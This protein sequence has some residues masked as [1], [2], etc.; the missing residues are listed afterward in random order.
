MP[1]ADWLQGA[2]PAFRLAIATS[3]LAPESRQKYQEEAIQQ[4]MEARP[5]WAEYLS[6][7]DRHLTPALSWAALSR[8]PGLSLPEPARRQLQKRSDACRI[9]GT[10]HSLLLADVLKEFNRAG[11]PAMPLKG[12][13]LS[14]ELYGDVGLRQ[15]DDL[16]LQVPKENLHSAMA[17]LESTGWRPGSDFRAMS[18][19]QWESFLRN[20]YEVQFTHSRAGCSLELHWRNHWETPDATSARW[21]RSTPS[22]WQGRSIR[23]MSA[24][25]LALFLC[26]HGAYHIWCC[27]KW[28]SDVARAHA[29]GRVD[30]RAAQEEARASGLEG[31]CP[32]AL[33]LLHGL[34]G[35]EVPILPGI[36]PDRAGARPSPLLV[37]M[38]LESL[39]LSQDPRGRTGLALLRNHSRMIRYER[40]VRPRKTWRES[41]SELFYCQQDFRMLPLP[42]RLFWA[43]K[44]LRPVL[45]LWRWAWQACRQPLEP[46]PLRA[47]R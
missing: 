30:W 5:D 29:I 6:L 13:V 1:E 24:G 42:D 25:D 28:L 20:G 18:P 2:S 21:A 10:Q 23:S 34:Y 38:P 15:S 11:I 45:W 16:D 40:L 14:F 37:E 9:Q 32:A 44:P 19:R 17:C 39:R 12:P 7:V 31:V 4:A 36:A 33:S 22:V 43:Y 47:N 27:A 26:I 8:V 35:F 3:W 46:K 41:L